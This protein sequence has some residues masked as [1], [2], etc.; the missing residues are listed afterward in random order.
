[1]WSEQWR[2][3]DAWL[4]A[5]E[6]ELLEQGARTRRGGDF[7]RW[8]LEVRGGVL[9]NVRT[10]ATVEEHGRGRQFTR[11][12]AW[13]QCSEGAVVLMLLFIALAGAALI[14]DRSGI[15]MMLLAVSALLGWRTLFECANAMCAVV[16]A[17]DVIGMKRTPTNGR[18]TR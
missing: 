11:V 8:D 12:R 16:R 9:G 5:I 4:H 13:P 18:D 6:A 7:D 15:A 1:M 2:S 14:D 17:L 10:L 3:F